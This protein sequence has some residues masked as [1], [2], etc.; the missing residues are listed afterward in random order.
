M[1]VSAAKTALLVGG[2]LCAI[3]F[4]GTVWRFVSRIVSF[5]VLA[6]LVIAAVYV[7]Y[8]LHTGWQKSD[9][10]E[11][12]NNLGETMREFEDKT[13]TEPNRDSHSDIITDEE[14]EQELDQ[15]R[16]Q[17]RNTES[18]EEIETN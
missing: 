13:D 5:A 16:E 18:E 1:N 6:F 4:V 7:T 14:L 9:T 8:E 12:D 3:L 11:D 10:S 17:T 2:G 15:L